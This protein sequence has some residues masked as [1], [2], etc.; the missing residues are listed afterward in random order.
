[1]GLYRSAQPITEV[2]SLPPLVQN[3]TDT[4]FV[5]FDVSPAQTYYYAL[6]SVSP[7]GVESLMVSEN[8]NLTT[9]SA[10]GGTASGYDG[11]RITF[12][13]G[14]ISTDPTL[15]LAVTV[16]VSPTSEQF[17]PLFNQAEALANG[18]RRFQAISQSGLSFTEVLSQ[19]ATVSI[20]YPARETA[21]SIR[22]YALVENDW[23]RVEEGKRRDIKE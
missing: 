17:L 16:E 22:V 10:R 18:D 20:P 1:M 13:A 7:A 12:G 11:T 6:T 23:L 14:A 19:M 3:L 4:R 21:E 15:R 2:S 5:D 8:L 9:L